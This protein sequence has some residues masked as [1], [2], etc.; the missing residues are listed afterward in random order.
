MGRHTGRLHLSLRTRSDE[1]DAG[2]TIARVVAEMGTAGGHGKMAGAQI[3]LDGV[4][5]DAGEEVRRRFLAEL[6]K[7]PDAAPQALIRDQADD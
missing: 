7:D 1:Y 2:T 6:G 4:E 3:P 5:R